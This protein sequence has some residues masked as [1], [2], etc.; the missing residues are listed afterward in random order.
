MARTAE[1]N[2]RKMAKV[3]KC[4]MNSMLTDVKGGYKRNILAGSLTF[5]EMDT[6]LSM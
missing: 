5:N 6:H 2:R 3:A 4:L 1:P